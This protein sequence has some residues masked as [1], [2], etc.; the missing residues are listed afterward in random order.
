MARHTGLRADPFLRAYVTTI[1]QILTPLT[2]RKTIDISAGSAWIQQLG[3]A[4]YTPVDVN[5]RH[6]H[7]DINTPLPE[8]HAGQ[9]ELAISMG[10]LHYSTHPHAS[11]QQILATLAPGGDLVMMV[12]WLYPPHDR[13]IDR[14]RIAPRQICSMVAGRFEMLDLYAIGSVWQTP[15]H[16]AKR[17]VAGPF[18]GLTPA[19]LAQ[20]KRRAGV[21]PQ[22]IRSDGDVPTSWFGPLNVVIHASGY[23]PV[24]Q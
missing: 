11:M 17:L 22:R 8:H 13:T 16:I 9:Y 6:E 18:V 23:R 10:S 15:L 20:V 4:D 3:F 24:T 1:C 14:W 19:Q 5:G 21:Q 7:W 12:P 2:H